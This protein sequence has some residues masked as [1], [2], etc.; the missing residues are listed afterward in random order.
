MGASGSYYLDTY[1]SLT[2]PPATTLHSG[3]GAQLGVPFTADFRQDR[4]E[5]E[6]RYITRCLEE[7]SGNVTRAAAI[8]RSAMSV[9][10]S[11]GCANNRGIEMV[12]EAGVEPATKG[13]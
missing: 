10:I 1:S 2:S 4:R 3:E 6:R 13:L 9:T 8:V 12:P 7:S 5:F 11:P